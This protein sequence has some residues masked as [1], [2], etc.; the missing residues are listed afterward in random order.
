M[1]PDGT[2]L[3]NVTNLVVYPPD[4]EQDFSIVIFAPLHTRHGGGYRCEVSVVIPQSNISITSSSTLN[5]TVQSESVAIDTHTPHQSLLLLPV[6]P[7]TLTITGIHVYEV[8]HTARNLTLIGRAEVNPSVDTPLDVNGVWSKTYPFSDLTADG[9]VRVIPPQLVQG[10]P[11]SPVVYESTLTVEAMDVTT[12]D[13]GDYTFSLTISSTPFTLGTS[14][15]T[16]R[17]I[18]VLGGGH[19]IYWVS[20][21]RHRKYSVQTPTDIM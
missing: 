3:G 13:S 12:A 11:G 4:S 20:C 10:S 17:N 15:N 6:P 18:T 5:I 8:F 16:T 7:P 2:R 19:V 1:G 14:V 21:A 9:R